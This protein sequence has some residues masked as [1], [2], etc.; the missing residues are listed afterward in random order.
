MPAPQTLST[1]MRVEQPR[2]AARTSGDT[3][4]L[5]KF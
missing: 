2:A 1:K 4:T 5:T 3:L